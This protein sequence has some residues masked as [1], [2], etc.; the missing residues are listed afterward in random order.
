[1]LK[2]RYVSRINWKHSIENMEIAAM[3]KRDLQEKR[4]K[5]KGVY[6]MIQN[7]SL[8]IY[9]LTIARWT[10][11]ILYDMAWKILYLSNTQEQRCY[12]VQERESYQVIPSEN[13]E[14]PL[15]P[16]PMPPAEESSENEQ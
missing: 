1:M 7:L 14:D 13:S 9:T 11:P 16:I 6:D 12:G 5:I 10:N 3:V 2:I 4:Q 15:P 8:S